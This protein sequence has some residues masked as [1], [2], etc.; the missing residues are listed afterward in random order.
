[1][2]KI[3][4]YSDTDNWGTVG[5]FFSV[6]PEFG[7]LRVQQYSQ[8]YPPQEASAVYVSTGDW[9]QFKK[10]CKPHFLE[11]RPAIV[12]LVRDITECRYD[13]PVVFLVSDEDYE[14]SYEWMIEQFL[15]KGFKFEGKEYRVEREVEYQL[16]RYTPDE[17]TTLQPNQIFIFGSNTEGRHGKGAAK[18]AMAFRAIYGQAR[19]L[20]G[21]TYAIVTKDLTI[22]QP[23][24]LAYIDEQLSEL[25]GYIKAHP[26]KEFLMTKIGCGL[27]GYSVD[28]IAGLLRYRKIPANL[29]LP[30]EFYE[31]LMKP[32]ATNSTVVKID[33]EQHNKES[34]LC[35]ANKTTE[36]LDVKLSDS[37]V[38]LHLHSN[39]SDGLP[40]PE[41][42]VK[43]ALE[44]GQPAVAVT[45]HGTMMGVADLYEACKKFGVKFIAGNET[46]LEHP[47]SSLLQTK[48]A[49]NQLQGDY[50]HN[51]RFH[52]IVMAKSLQGYSNLSKLTTWSEIH[53]KKQ[54]G[55]RKPYPLITLEKLEEFK[56]GL[57]VTSGCI[58]SLV[59]Q[60]IVNDEPE[61]AR[62][63]LKWYQETFGENFYIELQDHDGLEIYQ[64][65]NF[66]LVRL[67]QELGCQF[68]ITADSHYLKDCHYEV[69][70]ILYCI[71][72]GKTLSQLETDSFR[73][74]RDLTFGK[75][76]ELA[77]R[78]YY[79]P[80]E[81]VDAALG[82][83]VKLAESVS[84][85]EL[86]RDPTTPEFEVPSGHTY[87]SWF[88]HICE[89]GLRDRFKGE[90]PPQ[91]YKDRL[92]EE[93]EVINSMGF[94]SYFLVVA[95][96]IRHANE[97]GIRVGVGRGSA[98]G[99]LAA[100][101]TRITGVDP[102]HYG[103]SFAR[104]LNKGRREMPD[105][106]TDFHPGGRAEMIRYVTEKYGSKR[107]AQICTYGTLQSRAAIKKVAK[108]LG[109]S[110]P[111]ANQ[112]AKMI[113][114]SR[115]NPTKL[116]KM[117]AEDTPV[118]EFRERYLK[119]T[120][121]KRWIDTAIQVSGALASVGVHAAGVVIAGSD[122]EKL[123]PLMVMDDGTV[124]TQYDMNMVPKFGFLKMD[125]LGL[126]NLAI[127]D[128]AV[129]NIKQNRGKTVDVDDLPMDDSA[130][131]TIFSRGLTEDIFQFGSKGMQGILKQLQPSTVEDLSVVNAL[132]R[133]GALDSGM[134]PRYIARKHGKEPVEYD[135]PEL[136][137]ALEDTYG[138]LVYQESVMKSSQVLAGFDDT[139]AD[140]LRSVVGKKKVDKM[141]KERKDFLEGGTSRGFDEVKLNQFF[142][143]VQTFGEY[144]FNKTVHEDTEIYIMGGNKPIK[145]C[146]PGD[147]VL[148]MNPDGSLSESTVVALHDHGMVPLW[149]VTFDDNSV[150]C[151]TLDHKWLTKDG[152]LP[153]W[154]ILKMGYSVWGSSKLQKET[155]C[156]PQRMHS[157]HLYQQNRSETQNH[158]VWGHSSNTER[159]IF[160]LSVLPPVSG[161]TQKDESEQLQNF[162]PH[163]SNET[164]VFGNSE[165][166]ICASG[167]SAGSC[168]P[169]EKMERRKSREISG[170]YNQSSVV[171]QE[172]FSN[173]SVV[174][175]KIGTYGVYSEYADRLFW[176]EETDRPNPQ[177]Q[178]DNHR[179][180]WSLALF[181]YPRDRVVRKN[182]T[183]RQN[184][185]CGNYKTLLATNS[186]I[187]GELQFP[188]WG[189]RKSWVYSGTIT[190]GNSG[191]GLDRS[192][193]LRKPV[194]ISFLGFRQGYD[195]EVDHPEHNFLLASGLCCSNSHSVGYSYLA[196]Q[197][198]YLKANYPAEYIAAFLSCTDVKKARQF[199]KLAKKSG[200]E[201]LPP[202]INI[203]GENFTP[204]SENK[205]FF[206]L[207]LIKD[208]GDTAIQ[209]I[210][211]A[212]QE[213]E[214]TSLVDIFLR[215]RINVKALSALAYSGALD[216]ICDNRKQLIESIKLLQDW[217]KKYEA[218]DDAAARTTESIEKRYTKLGLERSRQ[219]LETFVCENEPLNKTKT[220]D[221][222]FI[223]RKEKELSEIYNRKNFYLVEIE[224]DFT[225]D[226]R[227]RK[228]LEFTGFF[229]TSNPVEELSQRDNFPIVNEDGVE[230]P[231]FV[232]VACA[233]ID[234]VYKIAK[235]SGNPRYELVLEDHS[236]T[237]VEAVAYYKALAKPQVIEAIENK[238]A[239][240]GRFRVEPKEDDELQFMLYDVIT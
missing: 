214:F 53:N 11:R 199:I 200:V 148:S 157:L 193:V 96:Y 55:G 215:T 113:P 32:D 100:Y 191:F 129:A 124:V 210:L 151:C 190:E 20:Q 77:E 118:P 71:K 75:S 89:E 43:A 240:V 158:I 10:D 203:S 107:V 26:D 218:M 186:F 94:A 103:L 170:N 88:T 38:N 105:I 121:F 175:C 19:G 220:A 90:E 49:N 189:D 150:E 171:T 217:K 209:A 155:D 36:V 128:E 54:G 106:D 228:E 6:R 73:Y 21:Q 213:G 52:Q 46:Y 97:Q 194:R 63:I 109:I 153:L 27:A 184:V 60:L 3:V 33:K 48:Q 78:F 205:V 136:Q 167:N 120:E 31:V 15:V 74:D 101:A 182:T 115:G 131:Y 227:L 125:F 23:V 176:Q 122:I 173:G 72:Y 13:R 134:I 99:S 232:D 233:I 195:L 82:N 114:V 39:Y 104:F 181:A 76:G 67:G 201:V 159:E 225:M 66:A 17:I 198:A 5:Q 117:I 116:T 42:I 126:I 196:Y 145:D 230:P 172:C 130:T 168:C 204:S 44:A 68:I 86:F 177:G 81:L 132:Y 135:F 25:F 102:I 161:V 142:D 144:G 154:K 152:Q 9:E 16:T 79:L 83:T 138:V 140:Q 40:S 197:C 80:H 166:N 208:L 174:D 147:R 91:N 108:V 143:K 223:V 24:S 61:R 127:I 51:G 169:F 226:E 59:P 98:A 12:K 50:K 14:R 162:S 211:N 119:D 238:L 28:Q 84:E 8:L 212:R 110:I 1:M 95:D 235:S 146:L 239:F 35:E 57:I 56:D 219:A 156:S 206:G 41:E 192:K 139:R 141:P 92:A 202:D 70:S 2:L 229:I 85:Y 163:T 178:Q 221:V 188:Y 160:A 149:Q 179:S 7:G 29:R 93:L 222:E 216:C 164:K 187:D 112:V 87:E 236:G 185:G 47:L 37:F 183:E 123:I 4:R 45:D 234:K 62:E 137:E 180:G 65:L 22:N 111:D 133:P 237:T 231:D 165:E 34:V 58:G 18:A 224:D 64:K 207:R 69:H 30:K